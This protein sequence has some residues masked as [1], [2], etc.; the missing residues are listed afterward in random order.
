MKQKEN[1][2]S[3]EWTQM[4]WKNLLYDFIHFSS[5]MESILPKM[6]HFFLLYELLNSFRNCQQLQVVTLDNC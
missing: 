5:M 3:Y 4:I 2:F 6:S 1:M